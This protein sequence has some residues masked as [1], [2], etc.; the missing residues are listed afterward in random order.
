MLAS[1]SKN[2]FSYSTSCALPL[3]SDKIL[4]QPA[5]HTSSVCSHLSCKEALPDCRHGCRCLC[6]RRRCC[7]HW[8]FIVR[9]HSSVL[10]YLIRRRCCCSCQRTCSYR[11]CD[12]LLH[13][14]LSLLHWRLSTVAVISTLAPTRM[15]LLIAAWI[16]P[17]RVR[18]SSW[19]S[20]VSTSSITSTQLLLVYLVL[21]LRLIVRVPSCLI[22][23]MTV[24]VVSTVIIRTRLLRV[25]LLILLA[26][27]V[28]SIRW[29]RVILLLLLQLS[30]LRVI[31]NTT[32]AMMRL[33]MM[34]S[35]VVVVVAALALLRMM[36]RLLRLIVATICLLLLWVVSSWV[37]C[38]LH[39]AWMLLTVMVRLRLN[40]LLGMWRIGCCDY[41][42][43][44]VLLLVGISLILLCLLRDLLLNGRRCLKAV[45][46]ARN[47]L[48]YFHLLPFKHW[49]VHLGDRTQS[50]SLVGEFDEAEAFT[51]AWN[52]IE[53]HLCACHSRVLRSEMLR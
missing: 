37:L 34:S 50:L 53:D 31:T 14:F 5:N 1:P 17:F 42:C 45:L 47:S 49:A 25:V 35:L 22:H 27:R 6:C 29:I 43:F 32:V 18:S 40:V 21:I 16:T 30:L 44:S 12:Y 52:R 28:T 36:L 23:M 46:H 41:C 11:S 9:C 10:L 8:F 3:C 13:F 4:P 48:R 38:R 7:D 39:L 15:W 51:R 24:L 2:A 26:T 33:M 20:V 19:L